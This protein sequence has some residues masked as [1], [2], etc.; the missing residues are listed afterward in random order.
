M[1]DRARTPLGA[2]VV[3]AFYAAMFG[4]AALLAWIF[5]LPSLWRRPPTWPAPWAQPLGLAAG[6]ALG[7]VAHGASRLAARRFAWARSFYE[8]LADLLGPLTTTQIVVAAAA[9]GFG[10]ELLF[11]GALLP[12]LGLVPQALIFGVVH[13]TPGRAFRF[14][15]LYAAVM[16]LGLGG[17]YLGSGTI[18]APVLAHFTVNYFGLSSLRRR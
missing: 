17:L 7:L 11:R 6:V 13:W 2:G 14:W 3:L 16:G 10:E 12:L 18:L 5:D 4:V 8:R 15:P 1:D 9:S